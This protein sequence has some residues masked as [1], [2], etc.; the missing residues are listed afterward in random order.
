MLETLLVGTEHDC[1]FLALLMV[2]FGSG[3]HDAVEASAYG[4]R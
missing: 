3:E 4:C 2:C 1:L